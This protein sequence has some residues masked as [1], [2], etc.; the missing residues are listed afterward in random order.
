MERAGTPQP[1]ECPPSIVGSGHS[2]KAADVN[3]ASSKPD[4]HRF[5][6]AA[7]VTERERADCAGRS[8]RTSR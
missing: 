6:A 2:V 3:L 1:Q 8:S 5:C 7:S 4:M